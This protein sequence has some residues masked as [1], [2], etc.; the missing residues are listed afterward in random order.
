MGLGPPK[1]MK[2]GSSSATTLPGS[3]AYLLSS[4]PK[5]GAVERP[6]VCR[7]LDLC[8]GSQRPSPLSSRPKRSVVERPAVCGPF[9]ERYSNE[10]SLQRSG[11]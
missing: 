3:L 7:S 8:C 10:C 1:V 9:S 11:R 5:R 6:A 4:R 2:N